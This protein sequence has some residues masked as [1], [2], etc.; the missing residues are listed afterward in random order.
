LEDLSGCGATTKQLKRILCAPLPLPRHTQHRRCSSTPSS[1]QSTRARTR[2]F[3]S[4]VA[5]PSACSVCSA[6]TPPLLGP[7]PPACCNSC[8]CRSLVLPS[9]D[10]RAVC[11]SLGM[12]RLSRAR[13]VLWQGTSRKW[14][15]WCWESCQKYARIMSVK[16][17]PPLHRRGDGE[18]LIRKGRFPGKPS[19]R[20]IPLKFPGLN[21]NVEF[22]FP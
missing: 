9:D 20:V 17:N 14:R 6:S 18:L 22:C 12:A 11:L 8:R 16:I 7:A 3:V 10:F 19:A 15:R 13:C 5:A 4:V 1:S 2:L 21:S